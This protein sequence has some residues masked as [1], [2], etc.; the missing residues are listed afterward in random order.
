MLPLHKI[1]NIQSKDKSSCKHMIKHFRNECAGSPLP[2]RLLPGRDYINS[3]RLP[4]LTLK[5]TKKRQLLNE[6]NEK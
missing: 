2:Y 4:N 3:I 1:T 5:A 6:V